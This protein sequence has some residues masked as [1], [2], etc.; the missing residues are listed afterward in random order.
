LTSA[1]ASEAEGNNVYLNDD[2]LGVSYKTLFST[3]GL[4]PRHVSVHIDNYLKTSNLSTVEGQLNLQII[5][6]ADIVYF[7]GGDQAKHIRSWLNDNGTPNPLL[8]VIRLRLIN[9]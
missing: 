4:S 3:Y 8:D 1:A 9:N 2:A 5:K 7:N 6:Q